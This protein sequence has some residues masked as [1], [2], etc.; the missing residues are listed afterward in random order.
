MQLTSKQL[1]ALT[2]TAK[3]A[4][5]KA[6]KII[7]TSCVEELNI[8][9]KEMATSLASSVFTKIDL[10]CQEIIYQTLND[11]ILQ[12]DIG[13]LGE[14]SQDDLSRFKK[15]YFWCVD[16][17]DGTL[18]FIKQRAGFCVSIALINKQGVPVIGVVFNP[19]S[20]DLYHATF[21]QGAFKNENEIK[22]EY[23]KNITLINDDSFV[24]TDYY[25]ILKDKLEFK[26]KNI[27]PQ[28]L[29]GGAVMNAIWCIEH[30]PACYVKYPKK[31]EGGGSIWDYAAA[32]CIYNELKLNATDFYRQPLNLNK[33]G[34]AFMNEQGV[35]MSTLLD[36]TII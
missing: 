8:Q 7:Q 15:D 36:N 3:Q 9:T 11:S 16:P 23:Q 31:T 25:Q 4:A 19:N 18:S 13:W 34:S 5:L 1:L 12:F 35:I 27:V 30:A 33:K 22:V 28:I 26:N 6:G 2:Q 24:N 21:E 29:Q 17:L 20:S 10:E 32:T 14:E